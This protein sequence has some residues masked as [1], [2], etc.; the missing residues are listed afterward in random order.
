[1]PY[2]VG[3]KGPMVFYEY[4]DRNLCVYNYRL[5]TFDRNEKGCVYDKATKFHASKVKMTKVTK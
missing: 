2:V 3:T 5:T 4:A 1:M